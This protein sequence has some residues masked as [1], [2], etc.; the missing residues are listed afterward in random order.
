MAPGDSRVKSKDRDL[1]K[2]NVT[3]FFAVILVVVSEI[4]QGWIT[5][6]E[7]PAPKLSALSRDQTLSHVMPLQFG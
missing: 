6:V 7:N 1:T 4:D 5:E 3:R 2:D